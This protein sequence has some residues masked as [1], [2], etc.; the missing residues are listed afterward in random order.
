MSA[1]GGFGTVWGLGLGPGDPDLVTIKAAAILKRAAVI[2]YPA[3]EEGDSFARAIAAPHLPGGQKEIAVRMPLGDGAFPKE[4]IYERAATAIL[5]EAAA[6]RE[7][8]VLCEG[9]PFFYGSFQYLYGRLA[10]RCPVRIVPGVSSL[11]A[12]ADAAGMPL[13]ARNDVLSVIPAPLPEA[14]IAR[15]LADCEAAAILKLG[16]HLGKVRRVLEAAGL[17][18]RARYV[19]RATLGSEKVMALSEMHG[20]SAPYFSMLLVHKR[21]EAWSNRSTDR[22]TVRGEIS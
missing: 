14:E 11:M 20:E 17:V 9:D 4:D 22:G 18:D 2:A 10:G 21:A 1:R 15:R 19:E 7:V 6:G 13:T 16:R 8:A 3:P 5:A 12:C